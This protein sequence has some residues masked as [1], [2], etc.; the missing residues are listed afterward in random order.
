[1]SPSPPPH[2]SSWPRGGR[3]STGH[4]LLTFRRAGLSGADEGRTAESLRVCRSDWWPRKGHPELLQVNRESLLTNSLIRVLFIVLLWKILI[5]KFKLDHEC[6][7]EL[8]ICKKVSGGSHSTSQVLVTSYKKQ[9]WQCVTAQRAQSAHHETKAN[10]QEARRWQRKG[11]L[12]QL[13]SKREDGRLMSK[14]TILRGAQNLEALM[15]AIS[16]DSLS[17]VITLLSWEVY[18]H[19]GP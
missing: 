19:Q 8:E 15:M 11:I 3:A 10:R 16:I 14:R 9:G 13:A 5:C 17:G 4:L 7:A 12:S 18:A 1:M 2:S 6:R